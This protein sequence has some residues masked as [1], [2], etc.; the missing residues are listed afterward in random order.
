QSS[1]IHIFL[2]VVEECEIYLFILKFE[3]CPKPRLILTTLVGEMSA[4]SGTVANCCVNCSVPYEDFGV[5]GSSTIVEEIFLD[6]FPRTDESSGAVTAHSVVHYNVGRILM[7][8]FKL[9]YVPKCEDEEELPQV[10]PDDLSVCRRCS[11]SLAAL[12]KVYNDFIKMGKENSY[13]LKRISKLDEIVERQSKSVGT[14]GLVQL[15]RDIFDDDNCTNC[16]TEEV[17]T[18]TS[19]SEPKKR[20]KIPVMIE[21]VQVP[22][23]SARGEETLLP[24][25]MSE[26]V[27]SDDS[28]DNFEDPDEDLLRRL[29][30]T[31]E[32]HCDLMEGIDLGKVNSCVP[33][34]SDISENV[35]NGFFPVNTGRAVS[36]SLFSTYR[37]TSDRQQPSKPN[38][39]PGNE[40]SERKSHRRKSSVVIRECTDAI[41]FE[42]GIQ[43][44]GPHSLLTAS[45]SVQPQIPSKK[46]KRLR[47]K[48][49]QDL[50]PSFPDVSRTLQSVQVRQ[51]P[52]QKAQPKTKIS[53]VATQRKSKK[54]KRNQKISKNKLNKAKVGKK[55][56]R[57]KKLC[58]QK[59]HFRNRRNVEKE[60]NEV[61]SVEFHE[62]K[63]LL[64][65]PVVLL[66][67]I[68]HPD[69]LHA[70]ISSGIVLS[71]AYIQKRNAEVELSKNVS[72]EET[73]S[74][75]F[76]ATD[77]KRFT[78]T[79]K[80]EKDNP[81]KRASTDA[82][83][84]Q[85]THPATRTL[86]CASG[87][88]KTDQM[89]TCT[90]NFQVNVKTTKT[91]VLKK[92]SF[93][94]ELCNYMG[95]TDLRLQAHKK[96]RHNSVNCTTC[97][98][99]FA[100]KYILQE[101]ERKNHNVQGLT[102]RRKL[103]NSKPGCV[104][105]VTLSETESSDSES[106]G[107]PENSVNAKNANECQHTKSLEILRC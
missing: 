7:V 91:P 104:V 83:T 54:P 19:V 87:P 97:D 71:S 24:S 93:R 102:Y 42:P 86:Q 74:K 11:D 26:C 88:S 85:A 65:E 48:R 20:G 36:Y 100:D 2:Q 79:T 98:Q 75:M 53:K 9:N 103:R 12:W 32:I 4:D 96:K 107:I 14:E 34:S 40:N 22:Q 63:N 8:I 80:V 76:P 84:T 64:C 94:C 81:A 6:D 29:T 70:I 61:T 47:K 56:G 90:S 39:T 82:T 5:N 38:Q 23:Y 3:W 33:K 95:L 69:E 49:S 52:V 41:E 45:S 44:D 21:E 13:L 43:P 106:L 72:P 73:D 46:R 58:V 78:F 31:P 105:T 68:L 62:E 1:F 99:I 101:H 16:D 51:S 37:S 17:R 55:S 59:Y 30:V 92:R 18:F 66:T 10:N 77:L 27:V 57:T 28:D 15:R 67:D 89:E 50:N 35:V 25:P 60:S